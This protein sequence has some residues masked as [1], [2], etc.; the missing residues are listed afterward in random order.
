[1]IIPI[2]K[3]TNYNMYFI[4]LYEKET[5]HETTVAQERAISENN[6]FPARTRKLKTQTARRCHAGDPKQP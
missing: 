4:L 6:W 5:S 1:M 2:S 3:S